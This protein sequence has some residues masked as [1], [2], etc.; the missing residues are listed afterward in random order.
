MIFLQKREYILKIIFDT[1]RFFA[2]VF[3]CSFLILVVNYFY[4][5]NNYVVS[6]SKKLNIVI[7]FDNNFK[8]YKNIKEKIENNEMVFLKEYADTSSAYLKFINNKLTKEIC[9]PD[10]EKSIQAYA[11]VTPKSIPNAAFLVKMKKEL[12]KIYGVEEI[13]YDEDVFKEYVKIERTF[14]F[15]KKM[16]LIFILSIFILFVIKCVFFIFTRKVVIKNIIKN[17]ILSIFSCC[18]SF[19]LLQMFC[20]FTRSSSII[21][22]NNFIILF[23]I[24]IFTFMLDVILSDNL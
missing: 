5:F 19:F 10:I 24:A 4:N 6:L 15:Y 23:L 18:I 12:G 14:F 9:I 1:V 11:I 17:I 13:V 22:I 3:F 21:L 2:F 8:E 20:I 16:F 7:F